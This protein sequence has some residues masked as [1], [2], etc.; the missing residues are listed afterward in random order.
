MKTSL[1]QEQFGIGFLVCTSGFFLM[2]KAHGSK[3]NNQRE[4]IKRKGV[5]LKQRDKSNE[6]QLENGK[7]KEKQL[8]VLCCHLSN[9]TYTHSLSF[10][11]MAKTKTRRRKKQQLQ[12]LTT[13]Q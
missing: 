12:F 9:T 2:V 3:R 1:F 13:K 11:L 4:E 5:T 7:K 8:L 6:K 10:T